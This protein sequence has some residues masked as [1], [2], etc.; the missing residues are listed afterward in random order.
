VQA[1]LFV[2]GGAAMALAYDQHRS[3]RDVDALFFPAPAVRAAAEEIGAV[4][5]LEP[6][7]LKTPPR[8]SSPAPTSTHTP[9]T[10]ERSASTYERAA[11]AEPR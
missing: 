6:D 5:G 8:D 3:T 11:A 4:H 7:W 1:Q 2:V 10:R 9:W